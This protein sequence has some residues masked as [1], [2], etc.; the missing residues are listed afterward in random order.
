[1]NLSPLAHASAQPSPELSGGATDVLRFADFEINPGA[2]TLSCKGAPL[3]IGSRAF[4]LLVALCRR[5]GE[6]LSNA[7]LMAAAWPNR[8]VDEG[9]VRVQIAALRKALGE[10]HGGRRFIANV[11]LRGY[12]FVAEIDVPLMAAAPAPLV[13]A[14][15]GSS[16]PAVDRPIGA[17][18]QLTGLFGRAADEAEVIRQL[19]ARHCVTIVGTGGMGKTS[20]ARVVANQLGQRHGYEVAF[21]ELASVVAAAS[22]P[23][24]ISSALGIIASEA[25]P[26]PAVAASL[27][28]TTPRLLVLDNC[29]Q[30]VDAAAAVVEHLLAHA[31][32]LHILCTSRESLRTQDEWVHHLGPLALPPEDTATAEAALRHPAVELFVT[33]ASAAS[34]DFRMNDAQA[35][36]VTAI[37]RGLDGIPLAIELAASTIDVLGL[38][39]LVQRVG[40]RLALLARGRRTANPRQQTL[41]ATLDWSY[42]LLSPDEKALLAALSIFRRQ[43]PYAA[44]CAVFAQP[45]QMLDACLAGL[46]SKSLLGTERVSGTVHYFLLE[47]TREYAAERL[48]ASA[49][50]AA[51][52][53]RHATFLRDMLST[54]QDSAKSKQLGWG[55]EHAHWIDDVRV[56][57]HRMFESGASHAMAIS[58]TARAA[59]LFFAM[60]LLAEYRALAE[61]ALELVDAAE[62][63]VD[64]DAEDQMWLC[65]GLGHALW[66]MLADGAAM[67][68]AFRRA[69]VIAEERNATESRMRCLWGL[70]MVCNATGDYA[71]SRALAERFGDIASAS[72]DES[73]RL[74]HA[75]MMA[76]GLHLDGLQ[77]RAVHYA[78]QLLDEPLAVNHA[79]DLG[80]FQFDQKVAA[81]AVSARIDWLQGRPETA[82]AL[83][84]QA[85]CEALAI[86]HAL[87]LC[88]ALAIGAIP[89]A[90]WIGDIDQ[91]RSWTDLL[92]KTAERG[93]LHFWQAF[94]RNYEQLVDMQAADG[95]AA[96]M[97]VKPGT[98]AMLHETLCTVRPELMDE[99]ILSRARRGE[100]GW[101][102]PEMLRLAGER[103]LEQG[104]AAS[105]LRSLRLAL[106]V[107]RQQCALSW[108][109]RCCMSLVRWSHVLGDD[110]HHANLLEI[111]LARFTQGSAS[112]DLQR[113]V[114]MLQTAEQR[115][116]ALPE[117][118]AFS[119]GFKPSKAF[120]TQSG[121]PSLHA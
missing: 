9:G 12:C 33:R 18:L 109:L 114:R 60:S 29:E 36:L 80:R 6:I 79:A 62:A 51:T 90:F 25:D 54:S 17:P 108:E 47:T 83:A 31:P 10:G 50:A 82:Y 95:S 57:I 76:L 71:G 61:R 28:N 89:V 117:A 111:T 121:H 68:T 13:E 91:A 21:V 86:D 119:D 112:S 58:L 113:A 88:Y 70:W 85:V 52:A 73:T 120:P 16:V 92:R 98:N 78:R 35:Q 115:A 20:V 100:S 84:G 22:V 118:S 99:A 65:E 97:R 32:N 49:D 101:S 7:D 37:C 11:P 27:R 15:T 19:L 56:A 3:R 110:D 106:D 69:L 59:P 64:V 5:P 39:G 46:V 43:F 93:M 55:G 48:A 1:M 44:A 105:G 75:R 26:L 41:R 8:V 67:A 104:D 30:V 40:S 66:H 81:L 24:A 87:S 94:A 4:D 23:L 103:H 116:P 77:D 72:G 2:R 34:R 14:P 38:E 63:R 42:N 45:T 102:L 53:I 96:G 107:A 74:T